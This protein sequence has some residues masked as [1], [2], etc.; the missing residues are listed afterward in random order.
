MIDINATLFLQAFHFFAVWWI[1]DRFFFRSVVK[2]IQ[3]DDY[4][5]E[6]LQQS[7]ELERQSLDTENNRRAFLWEQYRQQFKVV[8][9]ALI[10]K[11]VPS[12]Q[13]VVCPVCFEMDDAVRKLLVDETAA[14]IVQRIAHE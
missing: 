12:A 7:L 11:E 13:S 4:V 1:V 14:L 3:E 10:N 6:K 5:V 8:T 2:A 9:P